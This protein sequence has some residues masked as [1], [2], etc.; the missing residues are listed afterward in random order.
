LKALLRFTQ[1]FA[2]AEANLT[3]LLQPFYF[4]WS[5]AKDPFEVFKS[6]IDGLI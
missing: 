1:A 5:F 4:A 6:H 2:S 3:F